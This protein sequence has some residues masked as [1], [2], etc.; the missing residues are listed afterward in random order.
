MTTSVMT[1][2]S[3]RVERSSPQEAPAASYRSG[4]PPPARGRANY[5]GTSKPTTC[6]RWHS[7]DGTTLASTGTDR[8]IA[9]WNTATGQTTGFIRTSHTTNVDALSFSADGSVLASR[10][11]NGTVMLWDTSSHSQIGQPLSD[12][13]DLAISP[14]GNTIATAAY[15]SHE[16]GVKLWNVHKWPDVQAALRGEA[17]TSQQTSQAVDGVRMVAI[18]DASDEDGN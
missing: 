10:D 15:H 13:S 1:W 3:T 18:D 4:A 8:T 12:V 9:L 5:G 2:P 16:D 17:P 11:V 6:W 14:D 7:P